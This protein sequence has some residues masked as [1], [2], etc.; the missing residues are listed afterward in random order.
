LEVICLALLLEIPYFA[1][2][3]EVIEEYTCPSVTNS[4]A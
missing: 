1:A 4:V 3:R 2:I